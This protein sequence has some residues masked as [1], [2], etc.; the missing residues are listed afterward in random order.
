M[1]NGT[2]GVRQKRGKKTGGGREWKNRIVTVDRGKRLGD[3]ISGVDVG[4][5][6]KE[7]RAKKGREKGDLPRLP[8]KEKG[9]A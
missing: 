4:K 5:K 7:K 9:E 8:Y 1:G 2:L 6:G 3:S